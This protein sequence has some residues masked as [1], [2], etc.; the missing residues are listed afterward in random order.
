MR[1][2]LTYANVMA[3]LGVFIALGGSSYAAVKITGKDVRNRSLTGK[4]IKKRSVPL[5][6]LKGSLPPGPAGP[7]GPA[8][9]KGEPGAPA[10]P[11]GVTSLA[12]GPS[13]W[14]SG[15]AELVPEHSAQRV[16]FASTTASGSGFLNLHPQL[17]TRNGAGRTRILAVRV[18]LNP[19]YATELTDVYISHFRQSEFVAPAVGELRDAAP[20]Q[21]AG[22]T[23]YA[24]PDPFVL[25]KDDF[26]DVRVRTTWSAT[27]GLTRIAATTI[28][29]DRVQ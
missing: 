20:S 16:E 4:D 10:P 13:Q 27:G 2:H 29:Y 15:D 9:P 6:R 14:V 18:C 5:N 28:E 22:C 3:T 17:P 21:A 26:V 24:L 23:R 11:E 1:R 12:V 8:G 7:V 19:Q 25:E